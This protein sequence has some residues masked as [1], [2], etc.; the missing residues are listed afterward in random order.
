MAEQVQL[1]A[2]F[3]QVTRISVISCT[4]IPTYM[5][6]GIISP[7][8]ADAEPV[9]RISIV[10]SSAGSSAGS[11]AAAAEAA[12]FLLRAWAALQLLAEHVTP[13][14]SEFQAY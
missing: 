5:P 4:H 11:S 3:F 13:F 7:A 1:A 10:T 12:D 14:C 8:T 6:A 2:A 9:T